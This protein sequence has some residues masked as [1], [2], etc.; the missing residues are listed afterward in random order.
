MISIADSFRREGMQQ[1]MRMAKLEDVRAMLIEGIELDKI[2]K[3]AKLN[4]NEI[5]AELVRM[6]K[7]KIKN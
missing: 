1:G 3:I 5:E 6:Q 7:E 2:T 4:Q